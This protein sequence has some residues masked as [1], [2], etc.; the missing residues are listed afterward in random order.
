MLFAILFII[1][2]LYLYPYY[3][4]YEYSLVGGGGD[5]LLIGAAEVFL[6][7][8]KYLKDQMILYIDEQVYSSLYL[9]GPIFLTKL[10]GVPL[11]LLY[12]IM[13]WIQIFLVPM[14]I[15]NIVFKKYGIFTSVFSFLF[16]ILIEM[17]AWNLSLFGYINSPYA[18]YFALPFL[19]LGLICI[20]D[21]NFKKGTLLFCFGTLIHPSMGCYSIFFSFLFMVY[22]WN[23]HKKLKYILYSTLPLV[24]LI[25]PILSVSFSNSIKVNKEEHLLAVMNWMHGVPWNSPW[26]WD[27][28]LKVF[29]AWAPLLVYTSFYK[30]ESFSKFQKLLH[31]SIAGAILLSISQLI[32]IKFKIPTLILLSGIRTWT[33]IGF[34]WLIL[35]ISIL[36]KNFEKRDFLKI[37]SSS[38]IVF[39]LILEAPYGL[40][41]TFVVFFLLVEIACSESNFREKKI[42]I[43]LLA[44]YF[45]CILYL[46]YF[47]KSF[48]I[49]YLYTEKS[50]LSLKYGFCISFVYFLTSKTF[51]MPMYLKNKIFVVYLLLTVLFF[52]YLR[53]QTNEQALLSYANDYKVQDWISKNIPINEKLVTNYGNFRPVAKRQSVTIF[54]DQMYL[55]NKNKELFLLDEEKLKLLHLNSSLYK[56]EN[57]KYVMENLFLAKSKLSS[58]DYKKIADYHE[59]KYLVEDRKLNFPILFE[60]GG[61]HVYEIK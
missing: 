32:G 58:D 49:Y 34:L 13:S 44:F 10:F 36:G 1:S 60:S 46:V 17:Q 9:Y 6:N 19:I 59:A 15:S 48:P 53:I 51:Q 52:F 45:G 42:Q 28:V 25:V 24:I 61:I 47:K 5:D 4:Y 16:I 23:E 54:P 12:F 56:K 11:K 40:N 57:L 39:S 27:E 55:Y 18:A 7:K 26:R 41:L 8:E 3:F 30:M 21:Y 20:S 37:F 33:L 2:L 29:I 35:F 38:L 31:A 14:F 43:G 50:L 22:T